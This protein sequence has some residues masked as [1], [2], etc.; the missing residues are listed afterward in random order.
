MDYGSGAV[1]GCPAHDQRDLDFA[2]AYGLP[3]VPVVR[4]R[5]AGEDF[6]VVDEAYTG[7][8]LLFNSGSWTGMDVEAGKA[9][10]IDKIEEIGAGTRKTT[11]RLRDW[12]VSRQRYWGCPIPIIH[13][14]ECGALAVPEE[15][16][17]VTLP[18][19]VEFDR[20]G[21][22]LDRHPNWAQVDCP[23]CG[24][25]AKR[26]TDTFDTF[27]RV[28]G[29]SCVIPTRNL[30]RPSRAK[31]LATGCRLTNILAV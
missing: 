27:L 6:A 21:N 4:P 28:P 12:G 18:E 1:F 9:A 17:P 25:A 2:N 11:Y 23:E 13:C 20:P 24:K 15:Q 22:P 29:I 26:E 7:P 30:M 5:D 14:P 16:L 10:A 19:D 31:L 8:G 3:V